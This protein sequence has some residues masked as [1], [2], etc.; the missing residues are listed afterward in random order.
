MQ[1]FRRCWHSNNCC[2]SILM[3]DILVGLVKWRVRRLR[4]VQQGNPRDNGCCMSH[5]QEVVST[6]ANH[7]H[8]TVCLSVM[9]T[10]RGL[11][12][13]NCSGYVNGSGETRTFWPRHSNNCHSSTSMLYPGWLGEM[14]SEKDAHEHRQIALIRPVFSGRVNGRSVAMYETL[15]MNSRYSRQLCLRLLMNERI[16]MDRVNAHLFERG[17][18]GV[19]SAHLQWYEGTTNLVWC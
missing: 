2:S 4:H 8:G 14:E 6:K 18:H 15:H 16:P 13:C 9:S 1:L 12:P 19:D 5:G 17:K 11:G 10:R 3:L 7:A